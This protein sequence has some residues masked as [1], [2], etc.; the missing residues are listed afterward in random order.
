M[1]KSQEQPNND[2]AGPEE[3][4]NPKDD[5]GVSTGLAE[6]EAQFATLETEVVRIANEVNDGVDKKKLLTQKEEEL[7]QLEGEVDSLEKREKERP[8][9]R[10]LVDSIEELYFFF[11]EARGV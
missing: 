6:L 3:P 8:R 4:N 7:K 5:K 11:D 2:A 10:K 9:R 1:L